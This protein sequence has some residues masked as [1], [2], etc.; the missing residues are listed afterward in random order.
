MNII[1]IH[2]INIINI[3]KKVDSTN[4]LKIVECME[5]DET[6]EQSSN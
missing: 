1:K 3:S 5:K 2:R 4:K 6:D